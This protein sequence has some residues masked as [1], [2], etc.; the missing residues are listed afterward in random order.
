VKF[1][2]QDQETSDEAGVT[3]ADSV[4]AALLKALAV[5]PFSSVRGL[6]WLNCLSNPTI[7]QRLA[8]SLSLTVRHL[9]WVLHRPSDDPKTIKDDLSQEL[10]RVLQRQQTRVLHKILVVDESWL[11]LSTD[12][13]IIW[14]TSEQQ[15]PERERHM[16]QSHKLMRT[17][18]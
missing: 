9:H 13:E 1:W 17:V 16:T 11:D 2:A 7:D 12:Q 5:N 15:V 14:L 8:E 4:N 3:R 6:S 18:A 10:L